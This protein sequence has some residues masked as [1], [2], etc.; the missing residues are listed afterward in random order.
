MLSPILRLLGRKTGLIA[1]LSLGAGASQTLDAGSFTWAGGYNSDWFFSP[2]WS[3]QRLP[4]IDDE[5]VVNPGNQSIYIRHDG[6]AVASLWMGGS[7]THILELG[8]DQAITFTT[9]DQAEIGYS[10]SG[11]SSVEVDLGSTWSVGTMTIGDLNGTGKV[12]V[13]EGAL[14]T[15]SQIIMAAY[16]DASGYLSANGSNGDST[17]DVGGNLTVGQDGYAFAQLNEGAEMTVDERLRIGLWSGS[18]GIINMYNDSKLTVPSFAVYIGN[19]GSGSL[20]IISSSFYAGKDV[21][22]ARESG[23]SAVLYLADDSAYMQASNLTL[24]GTDSAAAGSS[25]RAKISGHLEVLGRTRLWDGAQFTVYDD[26]LFTTNSAV[27]SPG[28]GDSDFEISQFGEDEG[29]TIR[30]GSLFVGA[31]GGGGVGNFLLNDENTIFGIGDKASSLTTRSNQIN[32]VGSSGVTNV[33]IYDDATWSIEDGSLSIGSV[34]GLAGKVEVQDGGVLKLVDS[35]ENLVIG[36]NGGAGTL[37]H[38]GAGKVSLGGSVTVGSGSGSTG[39]WSNAQGSAG[40]VGIGQGGNGEVT[41]TSGTLTVANGFAIGNNGSGSGDVTVDGAT[42][43]V[44]SDF[45]MD[46][47]ALSEVQLKNAATMQV[48]GNMVVGDEA[49]NASIAQAASLSVDSTAS[50]QTTLAVQGDFKVGDKSSLNVSEYSKVTIGNGSTSGLPTAGYVLVSDTNDVDFSLFGDATLDEAFYIGWSSGESGNLFTASGGPV[51]V[52]T[53]NADVHLGEFGYAYVDL[54]ETTWEAKGDS[55]YLAYQGGTVDFNSSE[56]VRVYGDLYTGGTVNVLSAGSMTLDG[57]S[58]IGDGITSKLDLSNTTLNS[59]GIFYVGLNQN[60]D[61][62]LAFGAGSTTSSLPGITLGS[63][64]SGASGT[65]TIY[66]KAS[67][68]TSELKVGADGYG[69]VDVQGSDANG[70]STLTIENTA[71]SFLQVA[72]SVNASG[73]VEITDG[74]QFQYLEETDGTAIIGVNGLG[75]FLVSGSGSNA[76]FSSS[77]TVGSTSNAIGSSLTVTDSATFDGTSITFANSSLGTVSEDAIMTLTGGLSL[78]DVGSNAFTANSNATVNVSGLTDLGGGSTFKVKNSANYNG[79]SV[80]LANGAHGTVSDSGVMTLTGGLSLDDVGS[81]TFTANSYATVSVG[82]QIDLDADSALTVMNSASLDAVSLS[83]TNGAE[84]I[85]SDSGIMTLTGDLILADAGSNSFTADNYATVTVGGQLYLGD[86]ATLDIQDRSSFTAADVVAAPDGGS[87]DVTISGNFLGDTV[88]F[89]SL[90]VGDATSGGG[91]VTFDVSYAFHVIAIGNKA[92]SYTTGGRQ[93]NVVNSGGKTGVTIEED[94]TMTISNGSL[95]IGSVAS[96][97]GALLVK[98]GATLQVTNDDLTIGANGGTGWLTHFG[99]GSLS[100]GGS[101]IVGSGSGSYGSW[102]NAR[103]SVDSLVMGQ[104]GYGEARIVGGTLAVTNQF[105]IGDDGSGYG[106]LTVDSGTLTVGSNFVIDVSAT[107]T[108]TLLNGGLLQVTEDLYLSQDESNNASNFSRFNVYSTDTI[109]S[110]L[111]VGGDLHVGKN[112]NFNVSEYS[113]V[114]IGN[115]STTGLPTTGYVLVSDND[116]SHLYLRGKAFLDTELYEGWASGEKGIIQDVGNSCEFATYAD[117]H[118]G[119]YGEAYV[120]LTAGAWDAYGDAFYLAYQGGVAEVTTYQSLQVFGD[121]YAG[122]NGGD[123]DIFIRGNFSV[124]GKSYIGQ[125]G[126]DSYL[127]VE[128][129]ASDSNT[130]LS[131][132]DDCYVGDGATGEIFIDGEEGILNADG[133]IYLGL[134]EDGAGELSFSRATT[135]SLPGIILGSGHK[136]ASG[137]LNIESG[138][139][140]SMAQLVVGADGYGKVVVKQVSD[141]S[142]SLI[143]E[144]TGSSFFEVASEWRSSGDVEITNGGQFEYRE[145]TDGTAIVGNVGQGRFLVSGSGSKATFSSSLTFGKDRIYSGGSTLTVEDGAEFYGTSLLLDTG[146]AGTFTG[147]GTL[148]DISGTLTVGNSYANSLI[149]E[150]DATLLVGGTLHIGYFTSCAILSGATLKAMGVT[151]YLDNVS[152]TFSPGAS[153]AAVTLDGDYNQTG[154]EL[155]LELGGT[156]AGTDYDVLTIT[157]EFVLDGYLTVEL[158]NDFTPSLGDSFTVLHF[159]DLESYTLVHNLPDLSAGLAWSVDWSDTSLTLTV[160][161]DIDG[162]RSEYG[163]AADGSDD[164]ADWSGNGLENILYYAF[165][166]GDPNVA[167][168]D[169]TY[170]PVIGM[171]NTGDFYYR[172]IR[173]IDSTELDYTVYGSLDLLTWEDADAVGASI[174]PANSKTETIDGSYE[175]RTLYFDVP[176]EEVIFIELDVTVPV[177]DAAVE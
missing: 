54:E 3:P 124:D 177:S 4:S 11:E 31:F 20:N 167:V 51:G 70:N 139:S 22:M 74:G 35:N 8:Y 98:D 103:G 79:A 121:F 24:G 112:A 163:L 176:E 141:E 38:S 171:D 73:D 125:S 36:Q 154:G 146:T 5:A 174:A 151:G 113:N 106:L 43:T 88:R 128:A 157:G 145:E 133:L 153:A 33:T 17:I 149:L 109:Q 123:V 42:L 169:W 102:E 126:A 12:I 58:N 135:G 49:Y 59:A 1:V 82:G 63:G 155:L 111:S 60:G 92:S 168:V 160:T 136:D 85:V 162:F 130:T 143:I 90:T 32:V 142:S 134:N 156:T 52:L 46:V 27:V 129:Y 10:G 76:S 56:S 83:L 114:T 170:L 19:E 159:S 77:V 71:S 86:G 84:G 61:G 100:V 175:Y 81:N 16:A 68:K 28:G 50:K 96:L 152:G 110:H 97:E 72:S 172:Y 65:L 107:S 150:D 6:L 101:V 7:G 75:A 9:T 40:S 15:D 62:E 148:V 119:D 164:Y 131:F 140:A 14:E 132:G 93:I 94:A 138:S 108:V 25:S 21:Y 39:K 117:V 34:S 2:N 30:F 13:N 69:K 45:E 47:N 105:D 115:G 91:A 118:L 66:D 26:G 99:T 64:H 158:I 18:E 44:G 165:G 127:L 37:N 147:S 80:S 173:L 144:N 89:N 120:H 104:E 53:T 41:L 57:I 116:Y 122:A 23:S 95:S 137:A 29:T 67:A 48:A 78:D 87:S 161:Y 55:L 166:I